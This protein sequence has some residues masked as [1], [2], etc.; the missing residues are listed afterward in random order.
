MSPA[1]SI[2]RTG[3]MEVHSGV[4]EAKKAGVKIGKAADSSFIRAAH[5]TRIERGAY[6]VPT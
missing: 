6:I 5:V 2:P 4:D 3:H 1:E